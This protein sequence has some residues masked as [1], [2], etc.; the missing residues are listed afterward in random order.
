MNKYS[1]MTAI[2]LL[3]AHKHDSTRA[4]ELPTFSSLDDDLNFT[5][6]GR[7]T[8]FGREQFKALFMLFAHKDFKKATDS[9]IDKRFA[10]WSNGW[11]DNNQESKNDEKSTSALVGH[12]LSS[13]D[14]LHSCFSKNATAP[15]LS[16]I[17]ELVQLIKTEDKSIIKAVKEITQLCLT[18]EQLNK[19]NELQIAETWLINTKEL[20]TNNGITPVKDITESS[21]LVRFDADK[22]IMANVTKLLADNS[23][24]FVKAPQF[25]PDFTMSAVI[26]KVNILTS[27]AKAA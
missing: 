5:Y 13:N 15:T 3:E 14:Y 7:K 9:T 24:C 27:T 21:I 20:L 23:M 6:K 8:Q 17:Y 12:V 22:S 2:E 10:N 11:L 19:F 25:N 16:A 4:F 26:G 18:N 1:N